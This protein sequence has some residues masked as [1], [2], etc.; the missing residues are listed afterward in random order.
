MRVPRASSLG[1]ERAW[2][3]PPALSGSLS[4]MSILPS[5]V[6]W[7]AEFELQGLLRLSRKRALRASASRRLSFQFYAWP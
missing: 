1:R 6:S 2:R 5:L 4:E 3:Q 7:E